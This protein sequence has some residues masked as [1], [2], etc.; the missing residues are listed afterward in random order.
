MT[1]LE[2]SLMAG[3]ITFVAMISITT[4]KLGNRNYEKMR[5]DVF[6]QRQQFRLAIAIRESTHR[7]SQTIVS[8]QGRSVVLEFNNGE[9]TEFS[10]EVGRVDMV[11]Q[12]SGNVVSRDSFAL[13]DIDERWQ[14]RFDESTRLLSLAGPTSGGAARID[15]QANGDD[16]GQTMVVAAV[17][18]IRSVPKIEGETNAK[19]S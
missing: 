17:G 7:C 18:I 2:T 8:N 6:N 19:E 10:I 13:V 4:V 3:L 12:W 9:S 16:S 15:S 14:F 11:S 5:D 1:L